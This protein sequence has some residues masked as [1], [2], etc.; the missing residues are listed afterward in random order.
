MPKIMFNGVDYSAPVASQDSGDCL[1]LNG[2]TMNDDSHLKMPCNGGIGGDFSIYDKANEYIFTMFPSYL[3]HEVK[4]T[5]SRLDLGNLGGSG[6]G[7]YG[8]KISYSLDDSIESHTST[9]SADSLNIHSSNWSS[10]TYYGAEGVYCDGTSGL[11]ITHNSGAGRASY[12]FEDYSFY[13]YRS[14]SYTSPLLGNSSHKWDS[15]YAKTGTIQTS[16]RTQKTNVA[17][18]ETE[19]T[20]KIIMGLIPCSYGMA[21]GTSGRTHYGLIAQDVEELL[22]NLGLT[23]YDFAGFIKSPK[24]NIRYE[25]ENGNKLKKPVEEIVEGEYDYALRYDEFIAPL[26]S[27]VQE[28]Q[29][30]IDKQQE[31]IEQLKE[32]VKF[33]K[34][35]IYSH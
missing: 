5:S 4:G 21:D 7:S 33:L 11:S 10:D 3:S 1:S 12:T 31:D 22:N 19:L 28:Q 13:P 30:T 24:K 18:L 26:I 34:Q 25:D 15:I 16:D 20:K 35:Y 32:D 6:I 29:K 14:S 9:L 2:G 27:V 17:N 8:L 23:S